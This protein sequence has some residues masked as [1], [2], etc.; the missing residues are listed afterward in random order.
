MLRQAERGGYWLEMKSL[1]SKPWDNNTRLE[2]EFG[3][4][5]CTRTQHSPGGQ[6][7]G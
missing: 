4:A 3:S 6:L 1:L 7:Q 2:T 5:M